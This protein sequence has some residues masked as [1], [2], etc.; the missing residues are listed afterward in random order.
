MRYRAL[1]FCFTNDIDWRR[2][3]KADSTKDLA[4]IALIVIGILLTRTVYS[5]QVPFAVLSK[6]LQSN[7][8][9]KQNLVISSSSAWAK[10]A[11][12]QISVNLETK[13]AVDFDNEMIVALFMGEQ[14]TAGYGIEV[15]RIDEDKDDAELKIYFRTTNPPPGSMTAQVLT[16]PYEIVKLKRIDLPVRFLPIE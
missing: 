2:R 13:R 6:G 12:T 9:E 11:S 8:R 14:R 1:W 5:E 4:A 15:V 16:R 10:L 3:R 7:V